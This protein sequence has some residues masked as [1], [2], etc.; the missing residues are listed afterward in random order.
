MYD[1]KYLRSE[2]TKLL[3]K[4]LWTVKFI[5]NH[6]NQRLESYCLPT[7]NCCNKTSN[8]AKLNGES[9]AIAERRIFESRGVACAREMHHK[10]S[11]S[12]LRLYRSDVAT[13]RN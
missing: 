1:K 12:L 3:Q 4:W 6:Q 13:N 2:L 10:M 8:S 9:L 5:E 7:R 11:V